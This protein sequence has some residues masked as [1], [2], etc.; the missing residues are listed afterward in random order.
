MQALWS[1]PALL[2][3]PRG[4]PFCQDAMRRSF[5]LGDLGS[6][7]LRNQGVL[8][9]AFR[10]KIDGNTYLVHLYSAPPVWSRSLRSHVLWRTSS[11]V[12][13]DESVLSLMVWWAARKSSQHR[14]AIYQR[15]NDASASCYR[16]ETTFSSRQRTL[17]AEF[18][19][20]RE[21]FAWLPLTRTNTPIQPRN[22]R[23]CNGVSGYSLAQ[24]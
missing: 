6:R 21:A 2:S 15:Q 4:S 13:R 10:E 14:E 8:T 5:P 23:P 12:L 3:R 20:H 22:L 1:R 24:A 7:R 19:V 17:R 18:E 16:R 9:R 11:Y